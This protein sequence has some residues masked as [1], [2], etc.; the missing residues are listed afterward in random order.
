MLFLLLLA[1][2]LAIAGL[3]AY[4]MTWPLVTTHLRDKHPAEH[5]AIAGAPFGRGFVWFL[6]GNH[7]HI[8]DRDLAF[9]SI[10]GCI[11][12][13]SIAIGSAAAMLFY[14]ARLA[15]VAP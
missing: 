9:L 11:G 4:V 5:A 3:T 10:P 13:W 15:G 8:A 12:A 14:L 7:R 1:L 6:R 2:G